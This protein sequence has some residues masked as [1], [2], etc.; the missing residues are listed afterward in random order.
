MININELISNISNDDRVAVIGYYGSYA[1]NTN[2]ILSDTDLFIIL[3]G[4]NNLTIE[5]IHFQNDKYEEI[6]FLLISE[7]IIHSSEI[8]NYIVDCILSKSKILYSNCK[9]CELEIDRLKNEYKSSMTSK[10]EIENIYWHLRHI[11]FK[12]KRYNSNSIEM[13]ILWSKFVYF[14]SDRKSVV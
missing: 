4:C 11:I 14:I 2:E 1:D 13:L 12:A 8:P 9:I 3:R 6:D 7:N 5:G 10:Q